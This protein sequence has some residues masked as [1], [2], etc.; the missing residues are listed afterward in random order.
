MKIKALTPNK[1]GEK[2]RLQP[3][4][5]IVQLGDH[6]VVNHSTYLEALSHFEK[7]DSTVLKIKRGN[8]D[9]DFS[10]IF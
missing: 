4:D 6:K 10:V 9:K 3:G 7:G 8:E 1:I 2:I 5:I